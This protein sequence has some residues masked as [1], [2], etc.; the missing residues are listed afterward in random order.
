MMRLR[1][2]KIS[3]QNLV[4]AQILNF[5]FTQRDKTIE[6]LAKDN[7]IDVVITFGH[8]LYDLDAL[9]KKNNGKPPMTY[10][11]TLNNLQPIDC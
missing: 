4:P 7:K 6:K 3:R 5:N 1:R 8:T 11:G 9:L 2:R 10:K